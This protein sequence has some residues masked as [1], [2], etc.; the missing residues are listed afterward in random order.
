ML[1]QV[2]GFSSIFN[3]EGMSHRVEGEVIDD[4]QVVHSMYGHCSVV[5]MMNR[6]M[7]RIRFVHS[8]NH[9]EVDR[10]A[11]ELESLANISQ[12]NVLNSSNDRFISFAVDHYMCSKQIYR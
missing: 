7:S 9:V 10:V 1:N 2:L 12:L 6:V 5:T 4:P 11:P 8:S 3:E